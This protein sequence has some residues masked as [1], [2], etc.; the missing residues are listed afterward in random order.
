MC[1]FKGEGMDA[2]REMRTV[3]KEAIGGA[4]SL[5]QEKIDKMRTTCKNISVGALEAV[6]YGSS[7]STMQRVQNDTFKCSALVD[8]LEQDL[9]EKLAA[10]HLKEMKL[11][12]QKLEAEGKADD[13]AL[14]EDVVDMKKFKSFNKNQA[15][16]KAEEKKKPVFDK[17]GKDPYG[18]GA[19]AKKKKDSKQKK[20]MKAVGLDPKTGKPDKK[21]KAKETK[22][23]K[24]VAKIEKRMEKSQRK[25]EKKEASKEASLPDSEKAEEPKTKLP[26]SVK[27]EVRDAARAVEEGDTK[28]TKGAKRED[29]REEKRIAEKQDEADEAARDESRSRKADEAAKQMERQ[30]R[31]IAKAERA[32]AGKDSQEL[33]EVHHGAN[34][35]S[36]VTSPMYEQQDEEEQQEEE[37]EAAEADT[38]RRA[39]YDNNEEIQ[40]DDDDEAGYGQDSADDY[41]TNIDYM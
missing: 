5:D 6:K 13:E 35:E 8:V 31:K 41:D 33:G 37:Q 29:R 32:K 14:K 1:H 11:K 15:D 7:L 16:D 25:E 4:A 18:V 20:D 21:L 23:D 28:E 19:K 2:V 39:S 26:E 40:G 30:K 36:V 17:D 10:K 34:D 3:N 12:L 9:H 38:Y 24:K 22:E 27:E